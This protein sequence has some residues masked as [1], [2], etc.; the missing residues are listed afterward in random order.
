MHNKKI[1]KERIEK[2][3]EVILIG[4][5]IAIGILLAIAFGSMFVINYANQV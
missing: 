3:I 4:G 1:R 2:L 5:F